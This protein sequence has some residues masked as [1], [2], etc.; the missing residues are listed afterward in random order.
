[1]LNGYDEVKA[2]N[3]YVELEIFLVNDKSLEVPVL[4]CDQSDD[5]VEIAAQKMNLAP[6]LS[7][8]FALY[9]ASRAGKDGSEDEILRKLEPFESPAIVLERMQHSTP[10]ARLLF[11]KAYW[12]VPYEEDLLDDSVA[13]NLLYLQVS[14][15]MPPCSLLLRCPSRWALAIVSPQ[16]KHSKPLIFQAIQDMKAKKLSVADSQKAELAALRK[17]SKRD[18]VVAC[19][20]LPGY[21]R[22]VW[23]GATFQGHEVDLLADAR[24]IS[25]RRVDG[26][27]LGSGSSATEGL[28]TP[29]YVTR[30]RCWKVCK[31]ADGGSL[32]F[33]YLVDNEKL[34]W[35]Y[36]MTEKAQVTLARFDQ[37]EKAGVPEP[38][39]KS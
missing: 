24:T 39:F 28:E 23:T 31:D 20:V 12:D 17:S 37:R 9:I 34:E 16:R 27:P 3:D 26:K 29:F 14:F 15:C 33:E 36:L 30:M 25:V 4:T 32:A 18:F 35:M 6:E 2:Y 1:M 7:H 21:G 8:Y 5:V 11:R 10:D 38:P 13:V 19:Q 22:V